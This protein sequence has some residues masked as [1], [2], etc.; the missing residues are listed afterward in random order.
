VRATELDHVI[1]LAEG[2]APFDPANL[3]P[4]CRSCNA[5]RAGSCELSAG[6][7]VKSR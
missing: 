2:G 5:R 6:P 4:S 3:A 1:A 7:A